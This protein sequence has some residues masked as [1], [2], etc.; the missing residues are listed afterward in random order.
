MCGRYVTRYEAAIE[1]YF[2]IIKVRN[3]LTDHFN[4]APTQDVPVV[5]LIDGERVMSN[6]HWGLIPFWANDKKIGY[7][8]IN[9]RAET[10]ASKPAFR[11]A[12]KARR[13][14]IPASG[15]YEWKRYTEPKT[16]HFIHKPDEEPL[17]FAGLWEKWDRDEETLESCSIVTTEAND[18]MA[19]LHNRMPV[20]LDAQDFD[21]WMEGDVREVGQLLTPCPSAWLTA[22]PIS[23]QVNNARNQGPELIEPSAA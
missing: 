16:P 21:W 19:D 15:F 8:T 6:M 23:R 22:N 5:R 9:A 4:V 20:I 7:K 11:A 13:C 12:Y 14:L 17:G 1:R 2:N 18:M 3:P 10:V